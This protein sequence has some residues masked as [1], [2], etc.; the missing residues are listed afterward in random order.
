MATVRLVVR[1]SYALL[2]VSAGLSV[3]SLW[4]YIKNAWVHFR[5]PNGVPESLKKKAT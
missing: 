4:V 3:W 5:Y 2:L 1:V